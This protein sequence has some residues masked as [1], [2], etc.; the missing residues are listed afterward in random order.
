M[1]GCVMC[2]TSTVSTPGKTLLALLFGALLS[3]PLSS[4]CQITHQKRIEIPLGRDDARFEVIPAREDGMFLLRR[5]AGDTGDHLQ[6]FKLDTAFAVHW[7]GF[8][9]I[10]PKFEVV[11]K[12]K[13]NDFLY[14]LMRNLDP[15]R[16]DLELYVISQENGNF[17]KHIIRNFIPFAPT[18]FQ[19]TRRGVV[20]GGYFNSVP[21]VIF[22]SFATHSSKILPGLL[23]ESGE[24]TQIKIYPDDSFDVLISA[25]NLLRQQ[26]IW[27]KSYDAEG[28]LGE[29]VPLQTQN[30]R[31]LIFARSVKTPGKVHLV[32]GTY[33][34]KNSEYSK[35]IFISN[36]EEDGSQETRYYG[37]GDLQNF[38]KYM[39]AS[40][41]KRIKER[42]ERRRIKGRKLRFNYRF[43]VHEI[44]PYQGQFILLG[45]A[46]YPRYVSADRS[47]GMSPYHYNSQLWREGRIFDGYRYTHAVVMGFDQEGRLL[48]DNSFEINDVKTFTLEQFVKLEIQDDRIALL[49]LFENQLRTKIIKGSEVLEGKTYAT[50]HSPS[51]KEVIREHKTTQSKLD[52]WYGDKFYASGV[53]EIHEGRSHKR[54]FFINKVS[55]D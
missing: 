42:I 8:L 39:K 6:I 40:R 31:H 41:E 9:N 49:Y 10:D 18:E 44:V 12:R 17:T 30:E 33:G 23:N 22:Y 47:M 3:L 28:N 16:K 55:C 29:H 4:F 5:F 1:N 48:W 20:V 52:Y 43:I 21:V 51:E 25:K 15:R 34:S 38:F 2:F 7:H 19:V 46:F 45:E 50:L 35:G 32:A 24:L 14:L 27:M 11:G 37:Y 36:I 26:T 53:Q 13:E 54:V